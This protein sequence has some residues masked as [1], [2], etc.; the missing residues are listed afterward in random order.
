MKNSSFVR[1]Y[2]SSDKILKPD[3]ILGNSSLL[4]V[5]ADLAE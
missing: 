2:N 4:S 1:F 3:N 5:K